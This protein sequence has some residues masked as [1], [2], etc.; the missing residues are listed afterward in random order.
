MGYKLSSLANLELKDSVDMY[1]FSIG[2]G[3]W[4]GG[5]RKVVHENFDEI[6]R[7]IGDDAIIVG[8]IREDFHG[9]VV[10]TY[11]GK[12]YEELK[13]K[14]PAILVTDAHPNELD[15][16]SL[17]LV[18]PLEKAYDRYE[19]IDKFLNELVSFVRGESDELISSLEES[20]HP[21]EMA[22]EIVQVSIPVLPG[23]VAVNVNNTA[24]EL[25]EWWN[26]NHEN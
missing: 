19:V 6:A 10:E 3:L 8:G 11:L 21:A 5:L 16:D 14:M 15:Q 18:I 12:E 20:P 4:K 2:D 9:E 25:R 26:R 13:D 24:R 22:G 1:I 7:E 17:R 23:I